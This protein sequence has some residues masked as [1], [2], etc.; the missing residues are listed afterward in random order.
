MK[1]TAK[2][3]MFLDL[4]RRRR[5]C[6]QWLLE[7]GAG[8]AASAGTARATT[9][10]DAVAEALWETDSGGEFWCET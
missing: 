10:C 8:R 4:A 6:A 1:M 3:L 2:L 5:G 7:L 9:P